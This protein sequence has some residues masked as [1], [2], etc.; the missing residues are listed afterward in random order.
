MLSQDDAVAVM[1]SI[2]R[3]SHSKLGKVDTK[4]GEEKVPNVR[5]ED[6]AGMETQKLELTEIVDFL[7]NPAKYQ[8]L[9]GTMP[10]GVL[11]VGA[12]GTG[13][14]VTGATA[15]RL[16]LA[17]VRVGASL[18]ALTATVEPIDTVFVSAPLLAVPPSSWILTETVALPLVLATGV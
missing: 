2:E 9:G 15:V 17:A 13:V 14:Y 11:L 4:V 12:P 18:T 7:K 10:K 5:F 3:I 1:E 6:V 8:R 16:T